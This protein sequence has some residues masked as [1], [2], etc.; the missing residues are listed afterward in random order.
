MRRYLKHSSNGKYPSRKAAAYVFGPLLR[1]LDQLATGVIDTV[2]GR[3]VHI[4][5][6]GNWCDIATSARAFVSCFQRIWPEREC[7]ALNR[8]IARLDVGMLLQE[9]DIEAARAETLE[10]MAAFRQT[11]KSALASGMRTELIAIELDELNM[12]E[13]A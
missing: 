3:A 12:K 5:N 11:R 9:G 1:T 13:V 8:L 2:K 4:E 7:T 10:L 6:N